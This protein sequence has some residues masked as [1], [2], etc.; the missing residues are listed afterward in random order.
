MRWSTHPDGRLRCAW[1]TV[2]SS[3]LLAD[4]A[5]DLMRLLPIF[6]P[7]ELA[8]LERLVRT[9]VPVDAAAGR[10]IVAEGE[11]GDRY[12]VVRDGEFE[13][14]ISG[15]PLSRLTSGDGFGEIALVRGVRRTATV[16]AVSDARLFA[17]E[18]R[19]FLD[20]VN[21]SPSSR[22][23][24]DTLIDMRLGGRLPGELATV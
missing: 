20:A 4:E 17:L 22:E 11:T 23:V 13:V 21:G 7:L 8:S 15:S 9:A 2:D 1:P 24:A 19:Y 10:A 6:A 12:Y 16:V 14:T 5:V 3:D 18:R